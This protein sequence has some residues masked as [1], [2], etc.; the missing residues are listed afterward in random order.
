MAVSVGSYAK[1]FHQATWAQGNKVI[2]SDYTL[3]IDGF[4]SSYLLCKQ[5]PYPQ[6]S[7]GE[8][9]EITTPL[10]TK[11]WQAGQVEFAQSGSIS[12]YE[13]D[14]GQADNLLI[15]LIAKGGEFDA[16]V[17]HGTMEHYTSKRRIMKCN[18]KIDT[19]D[20][21]WEN[22]TQPLALSGTINFHYYGEQAKGDVAV[23]TGTA[24]GA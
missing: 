18:I 10:G 15:A 16:W 3:V 8:A 14:L 6:L 9:V 19:G 7:T 24:G 23:L 11:Y 21:D 22:R 20:T 1:S 17:H 4:E 2:G 5:F 12:L 13:T